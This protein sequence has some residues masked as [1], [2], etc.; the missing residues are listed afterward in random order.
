MKQQLQLFIDVSKSGGSGISNNGNTGR[1]FFENAQIVSSI[2]GFDL[3]LMKMI[4]VVLQTLSSGL[5]IDPDAFQMYCRNV[6]N[7][8]VELYRGIFCNQVYIVF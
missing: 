7:S 6:V 3:H 4:H 1:R 8:Y 2:T 5:Q